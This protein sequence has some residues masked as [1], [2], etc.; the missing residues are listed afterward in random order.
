MR[1]PPSLHSSLLAPRG[2]GALHPFRFTPYQGLNAISQRVWSQPI[3]ATKNPPD[4]HRSGFLQV[5]S[6]FREATTGFE[7][8]IRVLQTLAL[9]LGHVAMRTHKN[10]GFADQP[11]QTCQPRPLPS[12]AGLFPLRGCLNKSLSPEDTTSHQAA[13]SR[14]PHRARRQA[15]P[16]QRTSQHR[17]SLCSSLATV[18]EVTPPVRLFFVR[19]PS[20]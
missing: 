8:V 12:A 13:S 2:P 1:A 11:T 19:Y 10:Y 14:T 5:S 7:P 20:T 4:G 15:S 6:H 18:P 17:V 3:V 16:R 9:P